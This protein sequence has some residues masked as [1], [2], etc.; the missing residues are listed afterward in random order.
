MDDLR[1]HGFT[2]GRVIDEGSYVAFDASDGEESSVRV[3]TSRGPALSIQVPD[4][5]WPE[6]LSVALASVPRPDFDGDGHRDV[7]VSIRERDRA[8]LAWIE[9]SASGFVSEVFRPRESWGS[10]PCVIEIDPTHHS[11]LLEVSVLDAPSPKARV[12]I[13][14]AAQGGAWVIDRSAAGDAR[15]DHEIA[16]RQRVL[17]N[18]RAGGDLAAAERVAAELDWLDQLRKAGEPVL[19][20]AEHDEEAR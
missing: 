19:E 3:V 1:A 16:L 2:I 11:V 5:R 17:Q 12:R 9:V 20:P 15:F 6:R 8:C 14:V 10:W 4:V 7:V 13:A 18:A